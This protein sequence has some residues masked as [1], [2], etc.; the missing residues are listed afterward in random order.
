MYR[1]SVAASFELEMDDF[2]PTMD[3]LTALYGIG[4]GRGIGVD[5]T[6]GNGTTAPQGLLNA[7]VNSGVTLDPRITDDISNTLND[8][9]QN[10]YF[11]VNA[12]YRHS[13]K[14][15]WAMSDPTYQWIRSLTD[16]QG[17]PLLEIRKDKEMIMGKPVL[18]CP[19]M[20]SYNASLGST[21]YM[22]FG[23][24]SHLV[25]RCSRM[26]IQRK[27][28]VPGYIDKGLALY[29]AYMRADSKVV[30]AT[31]GATPPFTYVTLST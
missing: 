31:N 13:P 4:F 19:S 14:C 30:D 20:P 3:Q 28:Q 6:V 22:V 9:F 1:A 15:A 2:Q 16:K 11:S 24:F 7:A 21:G 8:L 5:L 17:R 29:T 18:I 10:A 27:L 25:V 12:A 23:D 26:W